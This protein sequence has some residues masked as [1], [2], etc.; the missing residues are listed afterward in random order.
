[1]MNRVRHLTAKR[2]PIKEVSSFYFDY[3]AY[4]YVW[5]IFKLREISLG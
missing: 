4:C 1:M 3:K 2:E 5:F